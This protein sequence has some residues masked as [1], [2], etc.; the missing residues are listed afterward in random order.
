MTDIRQKLRE[1]EKRIE[2]KYKGGDPVLRDLFAVM[3][4]SE[5]SVRFNRHV[6]TV[7]RAIMLGQVNCRLS[8]GTV[9]ITTESLVRLWGKPDPPDLDN[10]ELLLPMW[11][12]T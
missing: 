11:Q 1:R 4:V 8:G 9:L 6:N 7:R 5:A 2:N 10:V 3:T 12:K